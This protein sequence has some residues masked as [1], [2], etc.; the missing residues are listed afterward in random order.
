MI[1]KLFGS[2]ADSLPE[3]IPDRA[4]LERLLAEVAL[5]IPQIEWIA[6]V[7]SNGMFIGSFPSKPGVETDRISAMS[8]AMYSLGERI[9]SELNNGNMQYTFAFGT[10]HD[11]PPIGENLLES[12][13]FLDATFVRKV[14]FYVMQFQS[15]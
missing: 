9:A 11:S 14:T 5:D 15:P 7:K 13:I 8:A 3:K 12:N 10:H 1:K 6:L 2:K 4:H